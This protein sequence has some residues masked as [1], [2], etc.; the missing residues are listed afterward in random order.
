MMTRSQTKTSTIVWSVALA[1]VFVVTYAI[2]PN[3]TIEQPDP[4][5]SSDLRSQVHEQSEVLGPNLAYYRTD[6]TPP[7][8]K[9]VEPS[10][11]INVLISDFPTAAGA[12]HQDALLNQQHQAAMEGDYEMAMKLM[13][14]SFQS[15]E[16]SGSYSE[17]W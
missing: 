7:I 2:S 13:G 9:P 11:D 12:I 15:T 4:F 8:S 3:M 6:N 17:R 14:Q 5:V 1:A 16:G 10:L